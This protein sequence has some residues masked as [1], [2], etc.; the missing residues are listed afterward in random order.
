MVKN[1]KNL[2]QVQKHILIH[3]PQESLLDL[4]LLYIFIN[5]LHGRMKSLLIK[6][7][8]GSS[9]GDA[10]DIRGGGIEFRESTGA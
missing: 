7:I 5:D 10:E 1:V 8:A 9:L 2:I 4:E 6:F 3:V